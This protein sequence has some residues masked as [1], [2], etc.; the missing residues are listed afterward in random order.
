MKK[1]K[2]QLDTDAEEDLFEIY[3]Y[4]ALND[5]MEDA[6]RL[7]DALKRA[8]NSLRTLPLRDHI[9]PELQSIGVHQFSEIRF[10]PYRIFYSI[11][12]TIITIH[13]VLDGRRDMQTLLE[14]RLMR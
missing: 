9:P 3:R 6:D 7:L 12:A 13:C 2:V 10:K 8:C 5:S 14:E 4:V 11:D 1:H